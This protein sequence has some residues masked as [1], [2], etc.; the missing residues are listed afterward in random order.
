MFAYAHMFARVYSRFADGRFLANV[1][2]DETS[3]ELRLEI[4]DGSSSGRYVGLFDEVSAENMKNACRTGLSWVSFF[5]LINKA[6]G[7]GTLDFNVSTCQLKV[8]LRHERQSDIIPHPSFTSSL[9]VLLNQEE[10]PAAHDAALRNLCDHLLS[11]A[12]LRGGDSAKEVARMDDIAQVSDATVWY[13][14]QIQTEVAVLEEQSQR[15]ESQ[16]AECNTLVQSLKGHGVQHADVTQML[17]QPG[18]L[19]RATCRIDDPLRPLGIECKVYDEVLLRLLKSSFC[20]KYRIEANHHLVDKHAPYAPNEVSTEEGIQSLLGTAQRRAVWEALTNAPVSW[21]FCPFTL[22]SMCE[23]LVPTAKSE[24]KAGGLFYLAYFLLF[25]T[26]SISQLNVSESTLIRFLSAIE[27]SYHPKLA[28]F[29]TSIHAIDILQA[30]GFVIASMDTKRCKLPPLDILA[31]LLA[32]VLACVNHDGKDSNFHMRT[33]SMLSATFA[34]KAVV[35]SMHAAYGFAVMKLPQ[36]N[37]L[38]YVEPGRRNLLRSLVGDIIRTTDSAQSDALLTA[39]RIRMQHDAPLL[40][41]DSRELVRSL[42]YLTGKEAFCARSKDTFR[43]MVALG[44]E[45]L[46]ALGVAEQKAGLTPLS[47]F[48]GPVMQNAVEFA[49][50][51]LYRMNFCA[52]PVFV[53]VSELAPTIAHVLAVSVVANSTLYHNAEERSAL[54]ESIG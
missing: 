23:A 27:A 17:Q 22:Q 50:Y 34:E 11:H 19:D 14:E 9:V 45:E 39:F 12:A 30:V 46:V 25:H 10:D 53:A 13:A 51:V 24:H 7:E 44:R 48:R 5:E 18:I 47:A 36:Y 43:Q 2:F 20:R 26:G 4:F 38:E 54:G 40:D 52:M 28:P 49:K 1:T 35:P 21:Q 8:T 37:L 15:A 6:F 42:I 33:N 29:H 16:I 31:L 41:E 32:S 3:N